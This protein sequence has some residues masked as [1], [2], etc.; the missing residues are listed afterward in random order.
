MLQKHKKRLK[1]IVDVGRLSESRVVTIDFLDQFFLLLNIFRP[2]YQHMLYYRPC[3]LLHLVYH[4][5]AEH[6][7]C[8]KNFVILFF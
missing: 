3:L 1:N 6:F 7:L 8:Y 5:G 4:W 2:I